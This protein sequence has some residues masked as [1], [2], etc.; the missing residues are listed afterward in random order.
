MQKFEFSI[1]TRDGLLIERLMISGKDLEEAEHKVKQ[2]YRHC[3]I[4]RCEAQHDSKQGQAA[5]I[6]DILSLIAK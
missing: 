5:S 6:E 2:I 3:E 1:R 4:V